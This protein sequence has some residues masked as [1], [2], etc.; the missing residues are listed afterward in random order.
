MLTPPLRVARHH[1]HRAATEAGR[2][3]E[4]A[5]GEGGSRTRCRSGLNVPHTAE[6]G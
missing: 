6:N 3:A 2:K 4:Q 1:L 5:T